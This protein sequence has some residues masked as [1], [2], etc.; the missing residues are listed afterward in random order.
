MLL[1]NCNADIITLMLVFYLY[2]FP[3]GL[4][5][6]LGCATIPCLRPQSTDSIIIHSFWTSSASALGMS[7]PLGTCLMPPLSLKLRIRAF[8][9][10]LPSP[11]FPGPLSTLLHRPRYSYLARLLPSFCRSCAPLP[12]PAFNR[13]YFALL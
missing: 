11:S 12:K 9:A 13:P 6:A 2:P 8:G 1:E 4:L 3:S 7:P 10:L 5:G